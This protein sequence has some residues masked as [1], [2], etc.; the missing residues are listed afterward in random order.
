MSAVLTKSFRSGVSS[1][2]TFLII[3]SAS[4]VVSF[5]SGSFLSYF[6]VSSFTVALFFL[7]TSAIDEKIL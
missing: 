2:T 1:D 6:G 7:N 5:I 3:L 4:L